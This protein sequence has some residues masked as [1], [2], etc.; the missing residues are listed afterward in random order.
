M[1]DFERLIDRYR[2]H[3]TTEHGTPEEVAFER[4]YIRGKNR[5]RYEIA[6]IVAALA[7]ASIG[8]FVVHLGYMLQ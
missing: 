5:A 4:G 8:A 3:N 1:P 2:I 6:A 7:L